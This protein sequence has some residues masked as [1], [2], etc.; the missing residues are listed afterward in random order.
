MIG[1]EALVVQRRQ[2]DHISVLAPVKDPPAQRLVGPDD[3]ASCRRLA[4]AAL[5]DQAQGFT[6]S[7]KEID[8]IDGLYLGHN[9]L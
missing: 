5:P 2:V 9:P 1:F 4:A 3:A 6:R 7:D 8:A